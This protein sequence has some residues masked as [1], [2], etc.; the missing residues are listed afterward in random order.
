MQIVRHI[1]ERLITSKEDIT[2]VE[3]SVE[4]KGKRK[5][6]EILTPKDN[7]EL[8]LGNK[9]LAKH[10]DYLAGEIEVSGRTLKLGLLVP[11]LG[12]L[13]CSMC[14]GIGK[15]EEGDVDDRHEVPCP[16]TLSEPADFSG[17]TEGDR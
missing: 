3:F 7:T 5:N 17:A 10:A 2:H 1:I 12:D 9:D 6:Y 11:H 16:C 4:T 14:E 15:V 13:H 8:L